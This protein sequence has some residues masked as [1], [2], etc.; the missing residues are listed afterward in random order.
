LKNTGITIIDVCRDER[1]EPVPE[2]TWAVGARVREIYE[3]RYGM[4]PAKDLRTK[5]GGGG[6]H[7]FAIYPENMRATIV[8][9]LHEFNTERQRQGE[10]F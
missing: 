6:S 3:M 4:L 2:L 7:C 8:K 1:I 10:L 9:I 5:T